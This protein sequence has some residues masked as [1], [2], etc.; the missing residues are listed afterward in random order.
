MRGE[1]RVI[2]GRATGSR[3]NASD[4]AQSLGRTGTECWWLMVLLR[5]GTLHH[6]LVRAS[7]FGHKLETIITMYP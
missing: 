6:R 3:D 5:M 7:Q 4:W 2:G 1:P